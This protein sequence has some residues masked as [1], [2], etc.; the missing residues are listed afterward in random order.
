MPHAADVSPASFELAKWVAIVTMA[1]DH[2]GKIVAPDWFGPTHLIGRVAFPLFVWIIASRLA[3]RPAAA[4]GYIRWLLPWAIVSQP[5]FWI[6]GRDWYDG[7]ILFT[8]LCGVLIDR[9]LQA[10]GHC[11]TSWLIAGALAAAG[12]LLDYGPAG[13]LAIP[14]LV[15][16]A[17]IGIRES[18]LALGV[19]GIAVNLP[20]LEPFYVAAAFASLAAVGVAAL[21]LRLEGADLPRLPRA[22]FY[23]FYPGHLLL[24]ALV[25]H[26]LPAK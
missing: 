12:L 7:N 20:A 9:A 19:I 8:L 4:A 15:A 21:S 11:W 18:L 26:L 2:V 23:A 24:L 25:A 14:V 22:F 10:Y 13:V 6:A 1:I 16:A 5:A 17:R 3:I